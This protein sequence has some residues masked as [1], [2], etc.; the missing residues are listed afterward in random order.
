MD[1]SSA[2]QDSFE[3]FFD[4]DA[5]ESASSNSPDMDPAPAAATGDN[6]PPVADPGSSHASV[7]DSSPAPGSRPFVDPSAN[8]LSTPAPLSLR[9]SLRL[10]I[11]LPLLL[12][13]PTPAQT[14]PPAFNTHQGMFNGGNGGTALASFYAAGPQNGYQASLQYGA[15]PA[16]GYGSNGGG[17]SPGVGPVAPFPVPAVLPAVPGPY[18]AALYGSTHGGGL[19]GVTL[20]NAAQYAQHAVAQRST[21]Q[22]GTANHGV[23]TAA[24]R[25]ANRAAPP[26]RGA[27][28]RV[29]LPLLKQ[30]M[31]LRLKGACPHCVSGGQAMDRHLVTHVKEC[32]YRGC[33]RADFAS[34]RD[35]ATHISK[36]H[37]GDD[38]T[39]KR[40]DKCPWCQKS[41]G[42]Q[43]GYERHVAQECIKHS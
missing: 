7:P 12:P 11:P 36:D 39:W 28:A 17:F 13:A 1:S 26:V 33:G 34:H 38:G 24:R 18:N 14:T 22:H 21:P 9:L 4:F 2:A 6:Q 29:A 31:A 42:T 32:S 35:L 41:F 43:D 10:L 8:T 40:A 30:T 25:V 16:G 37:A 20:Y 23:M 3:E 19:N 27:S 5:Y 15:V